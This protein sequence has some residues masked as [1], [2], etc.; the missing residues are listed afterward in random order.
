MYTVVYDNV[1]FTHRKASQRLDSGTNQ[2]N[3]TT[4]V[5]VALPRKFNLGRY[6]TALSTPWKRRARANMSL[7]NIT[8]SSKQQSQMMDQMVANVMSIL[9]GQKWI[10]SKKVKRTLLNELSRTQDKLSVRVLW[11]SKTQFFPLMLRFC[12]YDVMTTDL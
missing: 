9:L 7:A 5:V 4:S 3:A 6:R 2:T 11:P 8:P 10:I 1:N 12:S